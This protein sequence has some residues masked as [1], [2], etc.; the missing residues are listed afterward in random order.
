MDDD[1]R[2]LLV[3]VLSGLCVILAVVGVVVLVGS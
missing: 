2:D 1:V 3:H